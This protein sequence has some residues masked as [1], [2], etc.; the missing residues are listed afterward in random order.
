MSCRVALVI[1]GLCT[2]LRVSAVSWKCHASFQVLSFFEVYML[3]RASLPKIFDKCMPRQA[4]RG[5]RQYKSPS[6]KKKNELICNLQ[7]RCS[8]LRC[9]CEGG[10]RG[11]VGFKTVWEDARRKGARKGLKWRL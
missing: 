7:G 11:P 10:L 8:H 5:P 6:C 4:G 9:V 1:N 3:L 2:T